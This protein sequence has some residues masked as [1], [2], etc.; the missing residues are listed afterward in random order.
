MPDGQPGTTI[1]V[2]Q[3]RMT[4]ER[5]PGKVLR[6]LGRRPVLGWVV[7][8]AQDS[9]VFDHVVVATSTDTADDVV[10]EASAAMGAQVVRGPLND[11]LDRYS[12]ALEVF[13]PKVVVRLTA[14]CPLLDP[15]VIRLALLL[16][17]APDLRLCKAVVMHQLDMGGADM[18]A[19]AALDAVE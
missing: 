10:A 8:A 1:A 6:P 7:R 11:V 4:S 9:A 14:D 15:G 18:R 16:L 5:L 3:A 2:I 19:A 13:D 17:L 12:I